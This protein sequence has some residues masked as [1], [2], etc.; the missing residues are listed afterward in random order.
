MLFA[1]GLL[2]MFVI[3]GLGGVTLCTAPF[4]VHVHDTYY[5]VGH[6]HYVLFGGSVFGIYAGIYH[7]FPKITGRMTNETLGCIHFIIMATGVL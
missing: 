7:W 2:S 4:D 5:V 3:G 1:I 6:F